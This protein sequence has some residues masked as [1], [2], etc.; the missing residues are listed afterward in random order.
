MTEVDRSE[1]LGAFPEMLGGDWPNSRKTQADAS[2]V[3]LVLVEDPFP[4]GGVY[5]SVPGLF[6]PCARSWG[7]AAVGPGV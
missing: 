2:P 3:A 7:A 5:W 4:A 6:R 1:L